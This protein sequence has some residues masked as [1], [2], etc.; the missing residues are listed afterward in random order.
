MKFGFIKTNKFL[1]LWGVIFILN[2]I[3]FFLVYNKI[4]FANKTLAL[5]YNILVGVE[6]YGSGKNLY[7]LPSTG[8]L[9]SIVNLI[10]YSKLRY[11]N[12]FYSPLFIFASMCLQI[13]MLLAVLFL[14]SV[15]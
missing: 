6:W 8:F 2:I 11:S 9:L 13:T 1:F 15:N 14:M 7:L 10:L 3:T 5:K 4:G 12:L